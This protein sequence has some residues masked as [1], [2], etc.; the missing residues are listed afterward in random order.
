MKGIHNAAKQDLTA[1]A[2][3]ALKKV[4]GINPPEWADFVKTGT[5]K[6][7]PPVQDDWWYRRAGSVLVKVN[8]LGPVGVSKLRVK[9][10]SKKRRGYRPPEFRKGSGNILRKILQQLEAAG[11]VKQ[12]TKAGHKGRVITGKGVS[13][14]NSATKGNQDGKTQSSKQEN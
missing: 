4:E 1:S 14:L 3:E 10:G 5:N 8:D 7:R 9:Y 6:E 13:L 11:L 12:D 2:A